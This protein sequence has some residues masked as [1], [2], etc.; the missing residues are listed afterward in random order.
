M[1]TNVSCSINVPAIKGTPSR[2]RAANALYSHL[3]CVTILDIYGLAVRNGH[4]KARPYKSNGWELKKRRKPVWACVSFFVGM[5]RGYWASAISSISTRAPL[6]R[7]LTAN[8]QRA[9]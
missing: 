3:T 6:G 8:A 9:G 7:S 4:A 2:L 1:I 5:L